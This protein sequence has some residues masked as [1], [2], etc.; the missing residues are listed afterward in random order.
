DI[1]GNYVGNRLGSDH[2][3]A[4]LERN[5]NNHDYNTR[6]FGNVYAEVDLFKAI[7]A[8]TSIG[9]D[10]NIR[11]AQ[12]FSPKAIESDLKSQQDVLDFV[13]NKGQTLTWTNTIN[14][15]KEFASHNIQFLV[16]TEA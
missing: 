1:G 3:L 11:D 7:T 14:Y 12:T 4:T 10:Y 2:A 16:G 13:W 8:R 9:L 6:I 5:R 15:Q